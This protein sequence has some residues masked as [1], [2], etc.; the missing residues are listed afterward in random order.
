M[1]LEFVLPGVFLC[2]AMEGLEKPDIRHPACG[3]GPISPHISLPLGDY[4][5]HLD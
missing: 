1:L 3:L 5:D 2:N 4:E